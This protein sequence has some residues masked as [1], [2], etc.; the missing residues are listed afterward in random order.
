MIRVMLALTLYPLDVRARL[1]WLAL[2][3]D[4]PSYFNNRKTGL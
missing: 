3:F 2:Y 4:R 1:H